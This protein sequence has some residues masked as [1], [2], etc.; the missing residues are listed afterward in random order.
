MYVGID[1]LSKSGNSPHKKWRRADNYNGRERL[2]CD[3]QKSLLSKCLYEC[4]SQ[5][6]QS[7]QMTV[8][9]KK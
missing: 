3:K 1:Y 8:F 2:K 5:F 6:P 9:I 7:E 4:D